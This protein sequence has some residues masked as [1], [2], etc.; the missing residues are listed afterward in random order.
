LPGP[1]VSAIASTSAAIY[2]ILALEMLRQAGVQRHLVVRETPLHRGRLRLMDL[3]ARSGA[4]IFP[5]V[6]A[7]FGRPQTL[8]EDI[9]A[10]VGRALPR[11]GIDT[12]GSARW[13]GM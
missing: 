12:P 7:L 8:D 10:A 13:E 5:P 6:A 11:L 4:A 2:G 1:L 9:T 3:A